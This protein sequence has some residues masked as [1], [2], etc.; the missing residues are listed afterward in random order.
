MKIKINVIYSDA[1]WGTSP[2]QGK[3]LNRFK[4]VSLYSEWQVYAKNYGKEK[5]GLTT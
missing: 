2:Q 4:S 3:P 5:E 1:K